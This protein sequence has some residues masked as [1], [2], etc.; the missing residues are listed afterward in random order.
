MPKGIIIREAKGGRGRTITVSERTVEATRKLIAQGGIPNDHASAFDKVIARICEEVGVKKYTAHSLRHTYGT[1]CLRN[2]MD[3]RTLQVR[4]GHA[5]LKT[6]MRYLHAL[7]A[8][9]GDR[10]AYAP[11]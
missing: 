9:E 3:V 11:F 1:E 5:D 10:K 6:T 4:L 7:Q 2:G 8:I